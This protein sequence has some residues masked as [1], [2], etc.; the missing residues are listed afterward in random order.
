MKPTTTTVKVCFAEFDG[1]A[2][3]GNPEEQTF[4]HTPVN[5]PFKGRA[6]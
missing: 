6:G 5:L 2:A 1:L 3:G 4:V